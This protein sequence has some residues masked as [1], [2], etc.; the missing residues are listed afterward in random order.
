MFGKNA[1]PRTTKGFTLVELLV[2]ISVGAI[3]LTL[4]VTN[5]QSIMDSNRLS[6]A[7]STFLAASNLARGEA[8]KRG[9]RVAI[10]AGRNGACGDDWKLGVIVFTDLDRD[11]AV[12]NADSEIIRELPRFHGLSWVLAKTNAGG[13]AVSCIAYNSPG[14]V[15]GLNTGPAETVTLTLCGK[16]GKSRVF[17]FNL[18][19]HAYQTT[20]TCT[21]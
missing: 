4:G 2:T 19:G 1:R 13:Q 14:Q 10:C 9:S 12:D 15:D 3:V 11:C 16:Q 8:I 7:S 6:T 5:F 18:V 21:S 20:G 17:G